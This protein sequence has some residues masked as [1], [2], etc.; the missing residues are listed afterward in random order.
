MLRSWRSEV[1]GV[2]GLERRL[3][4]G[5]VT[6]LVNLDM[7]R[8]SWSDGPDLE[9]LSTTSGIAVATPVMGAVGLDRREQ[10]RLLGMVLDV[11]GAAAVL[12]LPVH[13][14]DG[15]LTPLDELWGADARRLHERLA[16]APDLAIAEVLLVEAVRARLPPCPEPGLRWALGQ[17]TQGR[18]VRTVVDGSGWS[19]STFAR[20]I[21]A[22][23]GLRPK[24]LQRVS[25]LQRVLAAVHRR[26]PV[27]CWADVAAAHGFAD[28]SHLVREFRDLTG[29]TPGQYLAAAPP[30]ANHVPVGTSAT[31]DGPPH[32]ISSR[33]ASAR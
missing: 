6:L 28:Q 7:D 33:A 8:L 4:N 22:A 5:D 17:L 10:R 11:T 12:G 9:R 27:P 29:L 26:R 21:A 18:S 2:S 1:P 14:L 20:R 31:S 32:A 16:A 23:T 13:A 15:P 3:P 24:Q 25:R 19:T 30:S